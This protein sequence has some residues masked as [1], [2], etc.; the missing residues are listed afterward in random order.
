M[1]VA[2]PIDERRPAFTHA[3]EGTMRQERSHQQQQSGP[4][5]DAEQA[6][7]PNEPADRP[8]EEMSD[9]DLDSVSGGHGPPLGKPGCIY[10]PPG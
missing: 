1:C 8:P 4:P 9:D 10:P 6:R 7:R 3:R 5:H 2:F